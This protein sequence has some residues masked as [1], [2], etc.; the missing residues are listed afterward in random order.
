[1][2]G[3]MS[4]TLTISAEM[5]AALEAKR[6]QAGLP[7]ID[8]AAQFLLACTIEADTSDAAN[9]GLSEEALQALIA[10]DEASGPAVAWNGE[11]VRDEVRQRFASRKS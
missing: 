9:L 6:K 8:A 11:A 3:F 2:L 4:T 7:T 10:E 1:M 5:A